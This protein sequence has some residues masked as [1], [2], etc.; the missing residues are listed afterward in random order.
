MRTAVIERFFIGAKISIEKSKIFGREVRISSVDMRI[1]WDRRKPIK[2]LSQN[3][4]FIHDDSTEAMQNLKH[5]QVSS[6][7]GNDDIVAW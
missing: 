5:N 3:N 2:F 6:N 1:G 7:K 4:I